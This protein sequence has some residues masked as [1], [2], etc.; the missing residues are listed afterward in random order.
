MNVVGPDISRKDDRS[1]QAKP[2]D[3]FEARSKNWVLACGRTLADEHSRNENVGS[4]VLLLTSSVFEAL[5]GILPLLSRRR[6]VEANFCN[7]FIRV[8]PEVSGCN[9]VWSL[10]ENVFGILQS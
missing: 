7:G 9:D 6:T 3:V 2:I 5:G 8:F 1:G 4:A 10:A